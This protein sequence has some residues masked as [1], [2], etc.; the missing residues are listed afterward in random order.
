[1]PLIERDDKFTLVEAI[2]SARVPIL[3]MKFL[4]EG[5]T[6]EVD[7]SCQNQEALLNTELL[8]AY[9]KMHPLVR[10]I[11]VLV[12][13][14]TRALGLVGAKAGHLS[15]YSWTLMVIYF[16]QVHPETQLPCLPT[17]YFQ[18][19]ATAAESQARWS[20]NLLPHQLLARFLSFYA[21]DFQWGAEA[22]GGRPNGRPKL[23]ALEPCRFSGSLILRDTLCI[24][25]YIYIYIL[26]VHIYI[27]TH[28]HMY[29]VYACR[30]LKH[31]CIL[32]SGT[33][34]HS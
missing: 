7:L 11:V 18:Q 15:S 2:W 34:M 13:Q 27:Y 17:L 22:R 30:L 26:G 12:K 20:C 3:K 6:L 1:M 16:L 5:R 29:N 25:T 19:G 28:Q 24:Y 32:P 8:K 23:W 21:F 9:A 33:H 14:W 31:K 10:Q 4:D